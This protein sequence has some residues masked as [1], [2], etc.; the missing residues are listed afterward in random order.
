MA[1][2]EQT[3]L[4]NKK[5]LMRNQYSEEATQ[6]MQ[7]K[8][9]PPRPIP[10]QARVQPNKKSEPETM[11]LG[12]WNFILIGVALVMIVV[13]FVMMSGSSNTGDTFNYSIFDT[14]RIVVAP[15]LVFLGFVLIAPAILIRGREKSEKPVV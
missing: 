8:K 9:R 2:D 1:F 13:G 7:P 5:P 11:P 6:I 4:T 12:K 14:S 3:L 15:L 10:A